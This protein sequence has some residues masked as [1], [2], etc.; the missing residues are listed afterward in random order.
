MHHPH[1]SG[2]GRR[3]PFRS[4]ALA[5]LVVAV[6]AA[7]GSQP[8]AQASP[9]A[10]A[11]TAA[12]PVTAPPSADLTPVPG[13]GGPVGGEPLGT[14]IALN[15]AFEPPFL[16]VPSDEPFLLALRNED[17]GIPHSLAIKDPNGGDIAVS[18]VVIGPARVDLPV[19][20]LVAGSYTFTCTVHPTMTGTL[21]VE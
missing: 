20:A 4:A 6:T 21:T 5:L 19:P 11:P 17:D 15:L 10:S 12:P 16:T 14:V 13:A 8:P 7:C 2:G 3:A 9:S 18:E 1:R